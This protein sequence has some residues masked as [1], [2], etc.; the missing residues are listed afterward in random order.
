MTAQVF[1]TSTLSLPSVDTSSSS[2]DSH[3]SLSRSAKIRRFF[4]KYFLEGQKL[5]QSLQKR[6]NEDYDSLPWY[7]K[8]RKYLAFLIPMTFWH[9]VWWPLAIRYNFFALY[10]T[11]YA[12][13]VVMILGATVAGAT[14]EGGGAVAFPVMTLLLKI[15]PIA[16]RDFSLMIQSC[17]MASASFAV[18]FMRVQVEW[19]ALFFVSIGAMFSIVIGLQFVDDLFDAHVKKMMFV[20]IW[21]SFAISLLILNLQKKRKTFDKIQ[22]F[23][24]QR[25]LILFVTGIV[26]GL[27]SA[28]AGSG[29]DICAFSML[30]LFFRV[31]EKVATPTTVI[32]MAINTVIG[33]YWRHAIMSEVA[34]LTWEYFEVA[35]PVVVVCAPIG[36][37]LSSHCH[38]QALASFVYILELASLIGFLATSPPLRLIFI[39]AGIIVFSL[40]F[41]LLISRLGSRIHGLRHNKTSFREHPLAVS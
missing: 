17:G 40:G 5:D 41:F 11:R 8:N 3:V 29:V 21:F 1:P 2:A 34:T 19:M 22:N 27:C 12:M 39:G 26:G 38:R 30:T 20:S 33:F 24:W 6:F 18:F 35:I 32:L 16:A 13:A 31:S 36:A 25:A 28:F 37:F 10:P 9:L 15:D 23:N 7:E 4:R 14:S